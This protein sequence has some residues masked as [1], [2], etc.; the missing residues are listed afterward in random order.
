MNY[1]VLAG[2][3]II[4]KTGQALKQRG[5]EMIVV[6]NR[7]E[8]LAKIKELIPKGASIDNGASQTL[9]EIGFVEYL[10]SNTHGWN[11]LHAAVVAEQ[12][13][14]KKTQLRKQAL[15]SDYYLG[16]VHALAETGEMVVASAT[17]SQLSHL[18]FTSPNLILV[19]GAQ[20]IVPTLDWAMKRL[21][22]YV[23][24]REDKRMKDLGMGGTELA[25][26]VVMEDEPAY[27]KRKVYVI[28]VQEKLGF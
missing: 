5:V 21:R 15:L 16:S 6:A 23:V 18:V 2:D 25:K 3:E 26:I 14:E 20:K 22:E 24:P 27:T 28:L 4:V 8:A 13:K 11:N 12:D 1:E 7:A 19:V 9:E 17:G 10:K